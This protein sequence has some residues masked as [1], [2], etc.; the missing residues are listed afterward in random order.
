MGLIKQIIS[1]LKYYVFS[2][3]PNTKFQSKKGINVMI[4]VKKR[5]NEIVDFDIKKIEA[6]IGKAFDE[7]GRA[8]V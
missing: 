6:A 1:Y 8:H 2:T 4:R 3:P 7:I 5:T